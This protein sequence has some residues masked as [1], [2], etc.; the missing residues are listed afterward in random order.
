MVSFEL[1]PRGDDIEGFSM[2]WV[3]LNFLWP[4]GLHAV[5]ARSEFAFRFMSGRHNDSSF[6]ERPAT[7]QTDTIE[8]V[9]PPKQTVGTPDA[10][11]GLD[12][13]AR[14]STVVLSDPL[15]PSQWH[16]VG[17]AAVDINIT[18]AWG[19]FTG[20]GIKFGVY[21]DGIISLC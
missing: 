13:F 1:E 2:R 11:M 17:T 9:A 6:P 12:V 15:L 3:G 16:N 7:R 18:E 10:A 4:T 8:A 19:Y 14:R 5:P 20:L 21:D